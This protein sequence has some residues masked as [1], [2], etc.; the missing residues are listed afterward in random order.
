[1]FQIKIFIRKRLDWCK[2]NCGFQGFKKR[3]TKTAITFAPNFLHHYVFQLMLL[4]SEQ[5]ERA[6]GNS[7][8]EGGPILLLEDSISCLTSEIWYICQLSRHSSFSISFGPSA[9]LWGN[10]TW[11]YSR[12]GFAISQRTFWVI[13]KSFLFALCAFTCNDQLMLNSNLLNHKQLLYF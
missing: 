5:Q 13:K 11:W 4:N 7:C 10:K 1:M 2:S 12:R 8:S 6:L 9:H 3:I